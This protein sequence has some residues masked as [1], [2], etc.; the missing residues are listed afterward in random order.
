MLD[1]PPTY[2]CEN[3]EC[4]EL[5]TVIVVKHGEEASCKVCGWMLGP[6]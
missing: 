4:P 2:V 1:G 5:G 6:V 3:D